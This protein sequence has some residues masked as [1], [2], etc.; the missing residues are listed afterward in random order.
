MEARQ[1]PQAFRGRKTAAGKLRR[2]TLGR[3]L[4]GLLVCGTLESHPSTREGVG[5][6]LGD[7]NMVVAC[8]RTAKIVVVK[9][10]FERSH[11]F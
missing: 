2:S 5:K 8:R 1:G 3:L 4:G 11:S 7:C 10:L 6:E 9:V